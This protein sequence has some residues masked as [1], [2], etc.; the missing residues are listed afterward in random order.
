V[1]E[2]LWRIICGALLGILIGTLIQGCAVARWNRETKNADGST[3]REALGG[4]EVGFN[5]HVEGYDFTS[6]SG[7]RT[8]IKAANGEVSPEFV[9]AIVQGAVAGVKAVATTRP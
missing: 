4:I 6:T 1:S 8:R 3:T 7:S 9:G 2:H 5:A